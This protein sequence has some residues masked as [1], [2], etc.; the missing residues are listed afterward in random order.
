MFYSISNFI[1]T[2]SQPAICVG[3]LSFS[4]LLFVTAVFIAIHFHKAR[5]KKIISLLKV[6]PTTSVIFDRN[7]RILEIINPS[8]KILGEIQLSQLKGC[9]AY[10]TIN[11]H[12]ELMESGKVICKNA[13]NTVKA[14]TI[15]K[16]EYKTKKDVVDFLA[17]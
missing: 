8:N 10:D 5:Y 3:M 14:N 12:P 15:H 7:L 17:K 6:L 9:M 13:K 16:F 4:V 11:M 2:L 1:L